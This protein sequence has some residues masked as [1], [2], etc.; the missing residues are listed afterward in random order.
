MLSEPASADSSWRKGI[1][2]NIRLKVES[3]ELKH[4]HDVWKL[5]LVKP[6]PGRVEIEGME[7]FSWEVGE[8]EGVDA[9]EEDEN[10]EEAVTDVDAPDLPD[11]DE[12]LGS[13]EQME[14]FI[15][16]T[17][18]F[19]NESASSAAAA[20]PVE[21]APVEAA[22]VEA[23]PVEAAPVAAAPV[24]AA[25][26]A[27]VEAAPPGGEF[28]RASTSFFDEKA[29]AMLAANRAAVEAL[30]ANGGDRAAEEML[31]VRISELEKRR[32]KSTSPGAHN[33]NKQQAK[34]SK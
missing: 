10:E 7:A 4:W 22:P 33:T 27:P 12:P 31:L 19:P 3:G 15:A 13:I 28:A 17:G 18:D 29:K 6:Y 14:A 1:G 11:K 32:V 8:H 21:A 25:P 34:N 5:G 20:A 26:V 30:R 9:A 2:E 23:A 24:E 16:A